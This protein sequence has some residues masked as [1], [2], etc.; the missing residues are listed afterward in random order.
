MYHDTHSNLQVSPTPLAAVQVSRRPSRALTAW[1]AA[2]GVCIDA[3]G[4]AVCVLCAWFP[5][6]A[7][8]WGEEDEEC[9]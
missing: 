7:E 9:E 4:F 6:L 8:R 2:V 5:A 1:A 3:L